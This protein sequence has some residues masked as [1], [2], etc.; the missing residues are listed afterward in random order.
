MNRKSVGVIL[1]LA[2]AVCLPA[3]GSVLTLAEQTI[4]GGLPYTDAPSDITAVG[5]L[6]WVVIDYSEKADATTITTYNGGNTALLEVDPW[7]TWGPNTGFPTF[8][9]SDGF[10]LQMTD[11]LNPA[12]AGITRS[13]DPDPSAP[14]VG[15]HIAIPAGSGQLT[16]WWVYALAGGEEGGVPTFTT[17]FDDG[18]TLTVNGGPDVRK[19]VVDYST[20]TAQTLAFNMNYNAGLFAM[21]V[22]SVPEPGTLVLLGLGLLALPV[23]VWRKQK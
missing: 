23:Y 17:T 4:Y 20:N 2:M 11:P 22:S 8:N 7:D 10:N 9:W 21:A 12:P 5:N 6:D 16:V 14:R 3:Q 18:T 19:T 1:L 15:T 13:N